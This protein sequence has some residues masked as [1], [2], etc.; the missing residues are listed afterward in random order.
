[1]GPSAKPITWKSV[2]TTTG[3]DKKTKDIIQ[4]ELWTTTKQEL[5]EKIE[6]LKRD[7]P[8]FYFEEFRLKRRFR[9]RL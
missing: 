1:M 2:H 9:L 8:Q 3:H 4:V 7:Y 6:R 5:F